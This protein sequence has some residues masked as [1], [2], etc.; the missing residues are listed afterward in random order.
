MIGNHAIYDLI[1]LEYYVNGAENGLADLA[2]RLRMRFPEA[3]IIVMKFYGPFD[4]LRAPSSDSEDW[5][6][7]VSWKQTLTLPNGQ[8]NELINEIDNDTGV[9]RFRDHPNSD[10][11][12]NK[13]VREIGGY[14]FHLPKAETP[15]KTLVSYLRFF[16]PNMHALLSE[17]G[18]EW[19]AD[20]CGQIVHRHILSR[21]KPQRQVKR[22]AVGSWG[23][24]DSCNIWMTTGGMPHPYSDELVL[25]QYDEKRGK[26]ALEVSQA[27]WID[28]ENDFH[29]DRVLYLSFMA[30][31]TPG[32]YPNAVASHGG[33]SFPLNTDA[34]GKDKFGAGAV[35]TI[36]V[37]TLAGGETTRINLTPQLNG[38]T[39]HPFRLVGT[40]FTNGEIEPLE[41]NFGPLFNK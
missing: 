2:R 13:V 7:L 11:A 20:M 12:I 32:T 30:S 22:A 18:H 39:T 29:N 6:T 41:F 27:G 21:Q 8:L 19:V 16:D 34:G 9:W 15:T 37:G 24:G 10:K 23:K 1:L 26:F 5:Q 25:N 31:D 3:I 35:H 40:V 36:P 17:R 4:A 33:Q 28:I 38:P 14:Q